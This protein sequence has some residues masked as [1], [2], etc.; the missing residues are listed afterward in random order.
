MKALCC[1]MVFIFLGCDFFDDKG[2]KETINDTLLGTEKHYEQGVPPEPPFKKI[3]VEF[4]DE[5]KEDRSFCS[6]E[7]EIVGYVLDYPESGSLKIQDINGIRSVFYFLSKGDKFSEED[8][9]WIM[10]PGV[11]VSMRVLFCGSGGI[12]NII[13]MKSIKR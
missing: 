11:K 12:A 1:F 10:R 2:Q 7:K 5:N 4:E 3:N 13:S 6:D 9:K 8:E